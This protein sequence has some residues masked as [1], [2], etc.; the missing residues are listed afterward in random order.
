MADIHMCNLGKLQLFIWKTSG[1]NVQGVVSMCMWRGTYPGSGIL[2]GCSLHT[3]II[4]TFCH[5]T[6]TTPA[7]PLPGDSSSMKH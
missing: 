7:E 4:A 1:W 3:I 6:C 5:L 2:V